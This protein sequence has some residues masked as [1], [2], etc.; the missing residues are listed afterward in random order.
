M[1]PPEREAGDLSMNAQMSDEEP[2]LMAESTTPED[3]DFQLIMDYLADDLPSAERERVE[4][5]LRTDANFR[6][7]AAPLFLARST[8]PASEESGAAAE[9]DP[10]DAESF[11]RSWARLKQRIDLEEQG[12][13][14]PTW[15]EKRARRTRRR[16]RVVLTASFAVGITA[17][18]GGALLRPQVVPFPTLYAH[19]DAP[20]DSERVMRLPDA[21][22]VSLV[23]GSHLDYQRW[24]VRLREHAVDLNG[25]GTFTTARAPHRPLV[26]DGAHVEV[27]S[28]DGQFTVQ[29]YDAEPVAYV[30]VQRGTATVRVRLGSSYGT[31]VILHG[32]E[33]VQV[34]PGNRIERVNPAIAALVLKAHGSGATTRR[35]IAPDPLTVARFN[36]AKSRDALTDA[37]ERDIGESPNDITLT[38]RDTIDVNFWNPRFWWKDDALKTLP[39]AS[40]PAVRQAAKGTAKAV[41]ERY[42]RDAGINVIRITFVRVR[43][44]AVTSTSSVQMEAQEVT[45]QFTRQQL[46]TGQLDPVRLEIVER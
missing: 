3:T 8:F 39:E 17:W 25:E 30:Q 22:R 31:E 33:L 13:H 23:R 20:R 24:F 18:L 40:L 10:A 43:R 15:E 34:G 38:G 5:R 16:R 19:V 26:V 12:V 11:A 27:R 4:E 32:G 36:I 7:I 35:V 42:A 44:D 21:A 46:E 28:A 41:W 9:P 1:K 2:E 6:V 14:T 29:A 37:I 45:V